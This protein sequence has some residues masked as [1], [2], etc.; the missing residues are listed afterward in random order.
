[1]F[2]ISSGPFALFLYCCHLPSL[3]P[4][5]TLADVSGSPRN[6]EHRDKGCLTVSRQLGKMVFFRIRQKGQ[7][8]IWRGQAGH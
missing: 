6:D 8:W 1:M 4:N 5:S 3:P 2:P 7:A